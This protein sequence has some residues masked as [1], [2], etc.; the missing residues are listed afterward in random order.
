MKIWYPVLTEV[1][2]FPMVLSEER[3]Q[4]QSKSE[5]F[6][7][8]LLNQSSACAEHHWRRILKTCVRSKARRNVVHQ[9]ATVG[10]WTLY[11]KK[12]AGDSHFKNR[13][14]RK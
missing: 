14:R 2:S 12:M 5:M 1:A 6:V 7:P 9:R 4:Y 11:Y 8:A 3:R 13:E 10:D